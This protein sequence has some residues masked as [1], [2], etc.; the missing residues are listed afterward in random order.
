[1]DVLPKTRERATRVGAWIAAR[2][3]AVFLLA[4]AALGIASIVITMP[5]EL[6]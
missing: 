3:Y 2:P 6:R 1:M 4:A 5:P